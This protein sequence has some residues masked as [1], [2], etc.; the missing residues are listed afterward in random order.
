MTEQ[1]LLTLLR[2]P[3]EVFFRHHLQV[4]LDSPQTDEDENEPFHFSGLNGYVLKQQVLYA[5]QPAQLLNQLKLQGQLAMAGGGEAQQSA[6]FELQKQIL[7]RLSAY[8]QDT[9][10]D[11]PAQQF[12]TH[13]HGATLTL[14]WGGDPLRWRL[15]ADGTALQMDLRSGDVKR[16]KI[17]R[18]DTLPSLWL[19]HLCANAAG[20][21]TTS[22][23]SGADDF[24]CLSPIKTPD[25]LALLHDLMLLYQQA[26]ASPLPLP[27]K[28]ACEFVLANNRPK[29]S[30]KPTS[31]IAEAKKIF[32]GN[33]FYPGEC[34]TSAYVQRVFPRFEDMDLDLF[35]SLA[36]RVYGPL[37][38]CCQTHAPDQEQ[39]AA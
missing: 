15:H 30:D 21:Y 6:L 2:Q 9:D 17:L 31:A 33:R 1:S 3:L 19:G 11:L 23:L 32:H 18:L 7:A 29:K 37:L 38:R 20:T 14:P 8:Q 16:K 13:A 26:W 28:T 24:I 22:V 5:S 34:Q 36:E 10:T 25:A 35:A 27:L 4:Q 39:E 12:Q